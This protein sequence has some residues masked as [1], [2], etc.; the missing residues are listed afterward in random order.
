MFVK[1]RDLL[2]Y[3]SAHRNDP[4]FVSIWMEILTVRFTYRLPETDQNTME[5]HDEVTHKNTT[6]GI[7]VVK[8]FYFHPS[9]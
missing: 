2:L 1:Q 8:D 6:Q 4:P 5:T 7:T 3:T 9:F